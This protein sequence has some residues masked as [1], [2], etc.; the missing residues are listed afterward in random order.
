MVLGDVGGN[1][2]TAELGIASGLVSS[3]FAHSHLS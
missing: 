1:A 2:Y 3:P